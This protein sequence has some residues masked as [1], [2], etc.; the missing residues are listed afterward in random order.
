[1]F[2]QSMRR[3]KRGDTIF[4][5]VGNKSDRVNER[6]VTKEEGAALARQFGCEFLETSAKTAQN[7]D[8]LFTNLVRVLRDANTTTEE[9]PH[10]PRRRTRRSVL[11]FKFTFALCRSMALY[12]FMIPMCPCR[13]VLLLLHVIIPFPS[14]ALFSSSCSLCLF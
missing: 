5:L 13:M 14:Y 3:V 4:M 11:F 12:S 10:P 2:R 9:P 7:V 1:M 8:R 6:E